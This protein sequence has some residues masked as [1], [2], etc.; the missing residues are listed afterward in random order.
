M[1][2]INNKLTNGILRKVNGKLVE[3]SL[4]EATLPK[5]LSDKERLAR[6]RGERVECDTEKGKL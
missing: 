2:I 5:K 1:A 4:K 3:V 6:Y